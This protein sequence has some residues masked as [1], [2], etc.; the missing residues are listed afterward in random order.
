MKTAHSFKSELQSLRNRG[1]ILSGDDV[2]AKPLE[3]Q[4]SSVTFFELLGS[5]FFGKVHK[6]VLRVAA[7]S[8]E[9]T[10]AIKTVTRSEGQDALLEEAAMMA[11]LH[12]EHIVRLIGVVTR[13]APILL[14]TELCEHGSLAQF[15]RDFNIEHSLPSRSFAIIGAQVASGLAFIASHNIVHRDVAARNCL[16]STAYR[17]KISDFGLTRR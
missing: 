16:V 14:I 17:V 4:R 5:G 6:G 9:Q 15:L 13:G 12:H 3:L 7:N 2:E 8:F 1:L 11:A 10:V